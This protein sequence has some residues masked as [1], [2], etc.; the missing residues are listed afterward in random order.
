MSKSE[1][2]DLHVQIHAR[3]STRIL[4]S[5]DGEEESAVWL[6]LKHLKIELKARGQAIITAPEWLLIDKELV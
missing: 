6:P 1:L 5:D 4:V 2:A 3:T